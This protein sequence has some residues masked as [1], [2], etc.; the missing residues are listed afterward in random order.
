VAIASPGRR[1]G[2]HE[3]ED[4]KAHFGDRLWLGALDVTNPDGT[5][6]RTR[7]TKGRRAFDRRGGLTAFT[8]NARR[9]SSL[10]QEFTATKTIGTTRIAGATAAAALV[11][12]AL[13]P[14][15]VQ[16][17]MGLGL[18]IDPPFTDIH[19]SCE[20]QRYA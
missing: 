4:L 9:T 18:S 12:S 3:V 20:H 10:K 14:T 7:G 1:A 19:K 8:R 2:L 17:G 11:L 16:M 13:V 15:T 5:A 6:R